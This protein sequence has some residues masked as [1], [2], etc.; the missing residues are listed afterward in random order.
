MSI[1][2]QKHDEDTYTTFSVSGVGFGLYTFDTL[3]A[4]SH[5]EPLTIERYDSVTVHRQHDALIG[6]KYGEV[7]MM[8]LGTKADSET[9]EKGYVHA[10]FTAAQA[11]EIAEVLLAAAREA[12]ERKAV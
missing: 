2:I 5:E 8:V 3:P 1:D 9:D 4:R 11:R 10:K 7:T 12:D 6:G